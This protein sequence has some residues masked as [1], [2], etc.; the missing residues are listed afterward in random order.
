MNNPH[1]EYLQQLTVK[2][3]LMLIVHICLILMSAPGFSAQTSKQKIGHNGPIDK[4]QII[5]MLANGE[6]VE[7]YIIIGDD[8][9][10]VIREMTINIRIRASI[11][12][13]GIHF[14]KLAAEPLRRES[15]PSDWDEKEKDYL[16]KE[17]AKYKPT[18]NTIHVGNLIEIE[19]SEIEPDTKESYSIDAR[20]T[21][22]HKK[23][24]FR[25]TTFVGETDF[26]W[27]V[28]S[29]EGGFAYAKF[30][31]G[32]NM[33]SAFF[34][35]YA[36]F[37]AS[38]F[39]EQASL[40]STIF[41]KGAEFF[42]A[43]FK[44]RADFVDTKFFESASF[45]V[46][47]FM[48]DADFQHSTFGNKAS[49]SHATFHGKASFSHAWFS[50]DADFIQTVF[51]E[52]SDFSDTHFHK[53]VAFRSAIFSKLGYFKGLWVG[54]TLDLRLCHIEEYGD[55]RGARITR[56]NFNCSSSPTTISGRIDLRNAIVSEAH[57]EDILFEKDVD[58]SDVVF[59]SPNDTSPNRN[60]YVSVFRFV[61]FD[62]DALFIRTAFLGDMALERVKFN[63]EANFRSA[64]FK[65][66]GASCE[67]RICLS[68]LSFKKLIL[69]WDQLPD[70]KYWISQTKNRIKS[71]SDIELEAEALHRE[72][73]GLRKERKGII[74]ELEPLP[75]VL[76]SLELNFLSLGQ[77]ADANQAYYHMKNAE[78]K[79]QRNG[80]AVWQWFPKQVLWIILHKTCG[81]GTKTWWVVGWFI[82]LY[83]LFAI[84]YSI[85]GDFKRDHPRQTNREFSLKD[86]L[87][88][89]PKEYF[90]ADNISAI[91][92]PY[93]KRLINALRFNI[94]IL[95]GVGWRDTTI[96]GKIL[97]IDYNWI[98]RI[99]WLLKLYL[100]VSLAFTLTK[101]F[102]ALTWIISVVL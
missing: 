75:Q 23:C 48:K 18:Q 7:G 83:L 90:T 92:E 62:S 35:K 66:K 60:P 22:F 102:T 49:F 67:K 45:F 46:A 27:S 39:V 69:A 86:R 31:K 74:G 10:D 8:L 59:L 89:F 15:L 28:F 99:E 96:S 71:F 78:L 40:R 64:D 58:F 19:N 95:F 16:I 17:K 70:P 85:K 33:Q 1:T 77:L 87:F 24:S 3:L 34:R 53:N 57:F 82:F 32:I 68:Y 36:R 72:K 21:L 98:G 88:Y 6:I 37:H 61:T 9:I 63:R 38:T 94:V 101:T 42:P 100:L 84:V 97:M 43:E 13:G 54:T 50:D 79:E 20:N 30:Q 44:D 2:A 5:S 55:F 65:G 80:K 76:K 52:E 14:T 41:R 51:A 29:E 56:L 12:V 4:E 93:I 26:C 47:T 73:E 91:K 11:I 81:Y 25:G